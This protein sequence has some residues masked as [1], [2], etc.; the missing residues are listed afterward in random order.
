MPEQEDNG[1]EKLTTKL[2]EG[3]EFWNN[4]I[5]NMAKRLN[6]SAKDVVPLQAEAISLH[7]QLTEQIKSMSYQLYKL[8]PKIKSY[9]KQRFEY[10]AGAQSPYATNSSER[11]KLVEWDLAQLDLQKDILDIHIEFLRERLKEIETLNFAIK[12]KITLYQLTDI[13]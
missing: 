12:N 1:I 9:R 7:Q 6:C 4:T 5:D 8:L 3:E 13:E 11:T 10:Y 2:R